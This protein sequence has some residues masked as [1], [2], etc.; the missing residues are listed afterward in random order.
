MFCMTKATSAGCLQDELEVKVNMRKADMADRAGFE[1]AI[2]FPLYTLSRRA[3]STT[4]PPV[5]PLA[6]DGQS[7][8]DRF[9]VSIKAGRRD[10]YRGWR[11]DQPLS[12]SFLTAGD[13]HVRRSTIASPRPHPYFPM[14][15]GKWCV[16]RLR[17]QRRRD[18]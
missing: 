3:P 5:R 2:E 7:G 15:D 14:Q 4:R 18:A 9:I 12:D 17:K 6:A 13:N 8:A 11:Q 10:I 16:L 1:P